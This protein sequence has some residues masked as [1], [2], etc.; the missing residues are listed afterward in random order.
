MSKKLTIQ[1]VEHIAQLARVGL[2][3]VEKEK[4]QN[5]L[6]AILDYIDTLEKVDVS[7]V[8]PTGHV[9]G[10]ENEMREDENGSSHADD[11]TLLDMAPEKRDGYVKVRQVLTKEV[12]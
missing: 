4:F 5:D 10:L 3:T 7:K 8:E 11:A 1:E 2:S 6:G 9:T 12:Y